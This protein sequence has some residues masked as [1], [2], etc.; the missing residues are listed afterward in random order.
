VN[1]RPQPAHIGSPI[2]SKPFRHLSQIGIRLA[3]VNTSLQMRQGLAK[4]NDA[5]APKASF[6]IMDTRP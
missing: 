2:F 1:G 5:I 4:T 6:R 3:L